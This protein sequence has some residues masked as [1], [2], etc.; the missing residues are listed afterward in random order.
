MNT[1]FS[2][3]I[4]GGSGSGKTTLAKALTDAL[5]PERSTLLALDAY[6]RDLSEMP[7]QER[8][9]TNFDHPDSLDWELFAQHLD[10]LKQGI[11]VDRPTYDFTT[12]CRIPSEGILVFPKQVLV[13]EGILLFAESKIRD[14]FD[15]R[16]FVVLE[17]DL[18]LIRRLQRDTQTR[19]RT[20][21]SVIEQY[22]STVRP[23]HHVWVEPSRPAAHL[24]VSGTAP[25]DH[26]VQAI[27]DQIP[28]A[29]SN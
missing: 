24:V 16:V 21:E 28:A 18:R 13:V 20:V 25:V 15:L 3:G 2:I 7:V 23:M 8:A 11:C 1:V 9:A 6:Y 29:N 12:H 26:S 19:G 27:L 5:G 22:L 10:F 14:A 4:A 17:D